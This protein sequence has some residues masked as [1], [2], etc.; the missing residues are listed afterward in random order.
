LRVVCFQRRP[1]FDDVA[2]TI[3]TIADDLGWADERRADLVLFPECYL[4]GYS[5]DCETIERRALSL[6]DIAFTGLLCPL[7]DAK[8]AALIGVIERRGARLYNSAILVRSGTIA[9]VYSKMR[10]NE[11]AFT[12]G[13]DLPVFAAGEWTFGVNICFD[14]NFPELASGLAARGARLICYPLN[15]MMRPETAELWRTRSIENLQVRAVETGCW[16]VSS[17]VAGPAGDRISFGCTAIVS[18][19]GAIAARVP[20]SEEGAA[21]FDLT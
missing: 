17:D 9:G 21:I 3:G 1:R 18:P 13:R 10:P 5:T 7:R 4:Q 14:A 2:G 15:N 12:P 11:A 20:D 16:V 6:D 8:V 19:S